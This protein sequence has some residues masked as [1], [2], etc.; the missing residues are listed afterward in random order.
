MFDRWCR[1]PPRRNQSEHMELRQIHLHPGETS[2]TLNVPGEHNP[3][4]IQNFRP[5]CIDSRSGHWKSLSICK[6]QDVRPP[7][8]H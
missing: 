8:R 5:T 4:A 3:S 1:H 7:E 6:L 2:D